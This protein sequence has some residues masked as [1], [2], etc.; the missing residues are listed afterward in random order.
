VNYVSL[1]P[2]GYVGNYFGGAAGY[3][4]DSVCACDR[5]MLLCMIRGGELLFSETSGDLVGCYH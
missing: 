4:E 3:V 2:L 1:I 5:L